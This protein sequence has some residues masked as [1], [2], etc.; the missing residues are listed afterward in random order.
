M[1]TLF[2]IFFRAVQYHDLQVMFFV[3]LY[4]LIKNRFNLK[5]VLGFPSTL[6]Q[7]E[8]NAVVWEFAIQVQVLLNHMN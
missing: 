7:H 3:I 2:C 6:K 1:T 8:G 4:L 5:Q